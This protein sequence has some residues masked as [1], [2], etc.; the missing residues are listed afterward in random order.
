V[1]FELP[2]K[3]ATPR[4]KL[5]G[6]TG[7]LEVELDDLSRTTGRVAFDLTTLELISGDGLVD[8]PNTARAV[9]GLE[10]GVGV[11]AGRRETMRQV[12]FEVT[13][14]DAGHLVSAPAEE[15]P[16]RRRELVSQ[17]AVRGELS[18]HGVRAPESAEVTLTLV[19]GP[20][21]AGPP[22]ELLI[23]SRR[24]LVV[25]LGTHDIRPRERRGLSVSKDHG[26]LGD[27]VG[28]EVRVSFELRFTPRP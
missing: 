13:A 20:E 8:G 4:G 21:P 22:A 2:T 18:L 19:P 1:E 17:W 15:R 14:L 26:A 28:R 11:A 24:P 16:A 5:G 3:Q 7:E 23:R 6:A 12:L 27:G 9:D 25:E 10:L